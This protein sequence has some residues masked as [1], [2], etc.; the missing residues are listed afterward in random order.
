MRRRE[1]IS[2]LGSA[3]ASSVSWPR[4]ACAQQP[5]TP[6]IGLLDSRSPDA[7][8]D[9]LHAFRQGLKDA[10]SVEGEN[11]AIEYRFAE[12][13]TDRLPE[14]VVELVRRQVA[15]LATVGNAATLAAKA[16]TT[17]PTVFI[18]NEDP[19][20]LGLVATLARPG[21]NLTGVN[22]FAAELTAKR[23]ELL[24][25]L[26]PAATRVAVFVNPANATTAES[27]LRDVIPASRAMGLQVRVFKTS[28]GPAIEEAFG[29]FVR[30]RPDVL[31]IDPDPFF[32]GQRVQLV[33]LASR[34]AIPA[35]YGHREL[36]E[37][38]GL[39]SYGPR[40]ADAFRQAGVYAGRVLKGEK[41]ADLPVMQPTKFE[42]VLN[43]KAAKALG[44]DVPPK[45]LA[46]AD[47]VIE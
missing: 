31:F 10:G 1:F 27:T 22:F 16:T 14:L 2:L 38:G 33:Q 4:A 37:A 32:M 20:R 23:L 13:Q 15:M 6:M 39:M 29:T 8:R 25:E 21:R 41:P 26:V 44:I 18:V 35:T 19:V 9:R 12:N 17:I 34:H 45:F 43:L 30:E 36:A 11:V 46:L 5:S 42:L 7:V 28:T 40:L 47:E 3:A 24:R